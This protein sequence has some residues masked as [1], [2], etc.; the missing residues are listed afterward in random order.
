M[1]R[2]YYLQVVSALTLCYVAR[3]VFLALKCER[4]QHEANQKLVCLHTFPYSGTNKRNLDPIVSPR[5][6]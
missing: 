3:V 2:A 6:N 5:S 1:W 4:H